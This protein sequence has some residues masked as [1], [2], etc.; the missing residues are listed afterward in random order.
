MTFVLKSI[1]FT[2][3]DYSARISKLN[4][5]IGSTIWGWSTQ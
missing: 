3:S 4:L 5:C 1:N 2:I